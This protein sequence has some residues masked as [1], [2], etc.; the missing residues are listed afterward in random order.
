ME[1]WKD[2]KGYKSYYQISNKGNVKSLD[3]IIYDDYN[4]NRTFK[5]LVMVPGVV[6]GGYLDIKLSKNNTLTH[7]KIHTLV[8]NAFI[9]NLFNKPCV[10]HKDGNKLNNNVDNL[11]WVTYSE[12]MLHA[13]DIGLLKRKQVLMSTKN[14]K[15]LLV[16]S[17]LREAS[18]ELNIY[19]SSISECCNGKRK[20]AGGYKWQ[21]A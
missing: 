14:G 16:F 12:N 3:R 9:P 19:I 11:E 17:S 8:A 13:Y 18:R 21:F 4:G 5:G 15:P 2:I 1:Q 20:T 7:F 6:N 10:N